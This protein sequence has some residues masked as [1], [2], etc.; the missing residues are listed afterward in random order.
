M[1]W[2]S[3]A[4]KAEHQERQYDPHKC[5]TIETPVRAL[6]ERQQAKDMNLTMKNMLDQQVAHNSFVKRTGKQTEIETGQEY[7]N[8]ALEQ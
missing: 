2:R 6:K 1:E 5:W 8:R 7:V 3:E 4:E